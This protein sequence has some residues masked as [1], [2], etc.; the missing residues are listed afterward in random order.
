MPLRREVPDF[1]AIARSSLYEAIGIEPAPCGLAGLDDDK[2][3]QTFIARLSCGASL[4]CAARAVSLNRPQAKDVLRLVSQAAAERHADVFGR[5]RLDASHY[6]A[7]WALAEKQR[8]RLPSRLDREDPL[9][10]WTHVW[11]DDAIGLLR[12]WRVGPSPSILGAAGDPRSTGEDSTLRG[13]IDAKSSG[14]KKK[15]DLRAQALAFFATHHNFCRIDAQG[16]TPA[17]LAGAAD[18]PWTEKDMASLAFGTEA[19]GAA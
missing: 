5:L 2:P 15:I 4:R 16:M 3:R 9:S 19:E 18:R 1:T 11:I 14:F 6:R 17:M 7:A 12:H 10:V 13:W 8:H